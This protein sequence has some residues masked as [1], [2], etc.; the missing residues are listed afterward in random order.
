MA[1]DISHFCSQLFCYTI[2][3]CISKTLCFVHVKT[4]YHIYIM[5][6]SRSLGIFKYFASN[7]VVSWKWRD[8]WRK[9][10]FFLNASTNFLNVFIFCLCLYSAAVTCKL[11]HTDVT[12]SLCWRKISSCGCR[13]DMTVYHTALFNTLFYITAKNSK[14]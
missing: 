5:M 1:R 12:K 2:L 11:A 9:Q 14:Y 8:R 13:K 6:L 10:K 7:I 3:N 4:A